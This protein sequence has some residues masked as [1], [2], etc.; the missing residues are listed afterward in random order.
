MA[1]LWL[2]G[3]PTDWPMGAA[4]SLATKMTSS[5]QALHPASHT[6]TTFL[7]K[8]SAPPAAWACWATRMLGSH[9]LLDQ[10]PCHDMGVERLEHHLLS[11]FE[12]SSREHDVGLRVNARWD[13][14]Q[15]TNLRIYERPG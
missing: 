2:R 5:G 7:I 3:G 1:Q 15:D 8:T 12:P 4:R 14:T 11:P 10:L 9:H 13:L 6:T